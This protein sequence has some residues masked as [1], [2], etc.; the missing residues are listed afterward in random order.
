MLN[1][2]CLWFVVGTGL[3]LSGYFPYSCWWI[4]GPYL[5]ICLIPVFVWSSHLLERK[6]K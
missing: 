4:Y 5:A 3:K 6:R 2:V 1:L